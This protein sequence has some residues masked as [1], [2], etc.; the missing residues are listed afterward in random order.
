MNLFKNIMY[1]H[2][3]HFLFPEML[4]LVVART[5]RGVRPVVRLGLGLETSALAFWLGKNSETRLKYK[6]KFI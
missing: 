4:P 3:V 1:L 6:K 5:A 2:L